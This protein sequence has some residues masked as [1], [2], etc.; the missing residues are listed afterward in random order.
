MIVKSFYIHHFLI[1]FKL[2]KF[3]LNDQ[4]Y[5]L[6]FKFFYFNFFEDIRLS[7]LQKW[8]FFLLGLL[9]EAWTSIL[10]LPQTIF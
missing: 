4:F 10:A 5:D 1:K 6:K 3:H 2:N 8:K 9:S 7:A